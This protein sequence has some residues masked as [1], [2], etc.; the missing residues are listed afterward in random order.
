MAVSLFGSKRISRTSSINLNASVTKVFPLFNPVK[1][2]EWEA[3]WDPEF[4]TSLS[5]DEDIAERMVFKTQ[6]PHGHDESDYIWTISKYS[7]NLALIEYTVFTSDRLWWIT[8]QCRDDVEN[9]TT[10]A[11]ITYTFVGLTDKGNAINEKALQLMYAHDL[12]DWE[13]AI[14]HYLLTGGK[15]LH[16]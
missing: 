8:I 6:S 12:K 4:L 1:E 9:Q 14:N 5:E 15:L 7:L 3:G 13:E 2:K 10:H 11:E 16:H